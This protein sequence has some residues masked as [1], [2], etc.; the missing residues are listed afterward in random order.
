[1]A[2]KVI[3]TEKINITL[4]IPTK[5]LEK[6]E[7][8]KNSD[9][10]FV[11]LVVSKLAWIRFW[12]GWGIVLKKCPAMLKRLDHPWFR[13]ETRGRH[14]RPEQGG[15]WYAVF[16]AVIHLPSLTFLHRRRALFL[17][18]HICPC[19]CSCI[20][21][22]TGN[23]V[24]LLSLHCT[25]HI[26]LRCCPFEMCIDSVFQPFCFACLSVMVTVNVYVYVLHFQIAAF[27]KEDH[28]RHSS[29]NRCGVFSNL[30]CHRQHIWI[31][32]S[33]IIQRECE[34]KL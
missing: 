12:Y 8:W 28:T 11:S 25:V 5:S 9:L 17:Q 23:V 30:I 10:T 33:K 4:N 21:L 13:R 18:F 29:H 34:S 32:P 7:S 2:L 20:L 24:M 19:S 1:M 14:N 22:Q 3:L 26:V 16:A 27:R 15:M 6:T 31:K